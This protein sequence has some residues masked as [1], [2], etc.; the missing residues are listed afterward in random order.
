MFPGSIR[1][2]NVDANQSSGSERYLPRNHRQNLNAGRYGHSSPARE[3]RNDQAAPYDLRQKLSQK[4]RAGSYTRPWHNSSSVKGSHLSKNESLGDRKKRSFEREYKNRGLQIEVHHQPQKEQR[5]L[6]ERQ[7]GKLMEKSKQDSPFDDR[8]IEH[9][10][11]NDYAVSNRYSSQD[12]SQNYTSAQDSGIS[13]FNRTPPLSYRH[14]NGFSTL[15]APTQEVSYVGSLSDISP[16]LHA[17]RWFE[18]QHNDTFSDDIQ[19]CTPVSNFLHI[20]PQAMTSNYVFDRLV[21]KLNIQTGLDDIYP[22]ASFQGATENMYNT[23]TFSNGNQK[24]SDGAVT[25]DTTN[26]DT[27]NK[28]ATANAVSG[29]ESSRHVIITQMEKS[30]MKEIQNFVNG[31]SNYSGPSTVP[32]SPYKIDRTA[33]SGQQNLSKTDTKL[34]RTLQDLSAPYVNTRSRT[35]EGKEDINLSGTMM[36]QLSKEA[37]DDANL[38]SCLPKRQKV[39]NDLQAEPKRKETN[40]RLDY[41]GLLNVSESFRNKQASAKESTE[42]YNERNVMKQEE[43]QEVSAKESTE[44][45]ESN[46]MK[47]AQIQEAS[48]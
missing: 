36:P 14:D 27:I 44:G 37:T 31:P 40:R 35:L 1:Q 22:R 21:P 25:H 45:Y 6:I 24:F 10:K 11:E 38:A 41:L 7:P 13:A 18:R 4:R 2:R 8:V 15:S 32:Q 43:M 47:P 17:I 39:I 20:N 46:M 33:K 28:T 48:N 9:Q 23:N 42:G 3:R 29:G 5:N 34:K 26:I 19:G 16:K 30:P 12:L